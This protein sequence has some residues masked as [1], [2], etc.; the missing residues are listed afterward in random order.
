LLIEIHD[1][2]DVEQLT[3]IG[4]KTLDLGVVDRLRVDIDV[5][6]LLHEGG[7]VLLV[8]E[9]DF[10]EGALSRLI[11]GEG[12]KVRDFGVGE[13]IQL[14]PILLVMRFA[15]ALIAI[16]QPA[17]MGDAIRL[18][19]ELLREELVEILEG[20]V[21]EDMG[22][23]LGDAIDGESGIDR[24]IRH[25]DLAVFDDLHLIALVGIDAFFGHVID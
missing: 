3:L 23:D 16:K 2:E 20:I 19:V 11:I 13:V 7:E 21:L 4:V 22:M 17:A 25:M 1:V 14:S 18:I 12:L 8:L 24:H 5:V 15:K 6:A 9:F 10:H